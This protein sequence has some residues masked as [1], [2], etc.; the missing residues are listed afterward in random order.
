METAQIFRNYI[1]KKRKKIK[2]L[3]LANEKQKVS[4]KEACAFEILKRGKGN[5]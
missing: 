4:R 2:H 3:I 1:T 5:D